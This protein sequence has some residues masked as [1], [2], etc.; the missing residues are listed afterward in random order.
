MFWDRPKSPRVLKDTRRKRE[1]EDAP[2][3]HQED[4]MLLMHQLPCLTMNPFLR[5]FQK[6]PN[7]A[8]ERRKLF[9]IRLVQ[10][11][12]R[13]IVSSFLQL[14]PNGDYVHYMITSDAVV[15]YL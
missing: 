12:L 8:C 1:G 3:Q 7:L 4:E 2:R 5:K 6:G 10:V 9:L 15:P 14:V 11:F 13:F